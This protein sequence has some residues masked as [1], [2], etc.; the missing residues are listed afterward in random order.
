MTVKESSLR[1]NLSGW[2]GRLFLLRHTDAKNEDR[3]RAFHGPVPVFKR[4]VVQF[5]LVSIDQGLRGLEAIHAD[6]PAISLGEK[7]IR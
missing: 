2:C 5:Y 1:P 7:R 3:G 4:L 6:Q